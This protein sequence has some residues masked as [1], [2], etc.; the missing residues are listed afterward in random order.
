MSEIIEKV[1]RAICEAES[2]VWESLIGDWHTRISREKYSAMARAAIE[3]MHEPTDEMVQA[4]AMATRR[5]LME[6]AP[7]DY[8][9]P[10]EEATDPKELL[11]ARACI[12]AALNLTGGK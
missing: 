9:P 2:G 5:T 12:Q 8:W 10:I 1:A 4:G 11:V 7:G 6:I 3:A